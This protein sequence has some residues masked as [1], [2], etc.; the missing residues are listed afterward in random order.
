MQSDA[1]G[2]LAKHRVVWLGRLRAKSVF[3]LAGIV[4]GGGGG[5]VA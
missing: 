5:Q 2:G 4:T 3:W 1:D